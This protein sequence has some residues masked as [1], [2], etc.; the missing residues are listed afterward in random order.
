[1]LLG[2]AGRLSSQKPQGERRGRA[3]DRAGKKSEIVGLEEAT[4]NNSI[5]KKAEAKSRNASKGKGIKRVTKKA[6]THSSKKEES[7]EEEDNE[8]RRSSL[9][10]KLDQS[11]ARANRELGMMGK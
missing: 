10:M 2:K 8:A 3:P 1:M 5:T 11:T 7:Q 9:K 6:R 4:W